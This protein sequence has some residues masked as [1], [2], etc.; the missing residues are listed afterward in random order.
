MARC[1]RVVL[2]SQAFIGLI[3]LARWYLVKWSPYIFFFSSS[4]CVWCSCGE[5]VAFTLSGGGVA[6]VGWESC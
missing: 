5:K 4:V 6:S 2:Y 3:L 1:G